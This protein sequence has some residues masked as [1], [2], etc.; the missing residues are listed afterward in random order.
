MR[1]NYCSQQATER[2]PST[3]GDVCR[4]HAMEFWTGLLAHAR[5]CRE[6]ATAANAGVSAAPP[7]LD[8]TDQKKTD[9]RAQR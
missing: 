8:G 2:I 6:T 3:G 7:V 5:V 4:A 9:N 1:C